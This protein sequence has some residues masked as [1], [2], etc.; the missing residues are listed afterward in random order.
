MTM[1]LVGGFALGVG[2]PLLLCVR[3]TLVEIGLPFVRKSD[4]PGYVESRVLLGRIPACSASTIFPP[5]GILIVAEHR[6]MIPIS[7]ARGCSSS[8][9][10]GAE[11]PH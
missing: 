3:E 9:S 6:R 5:P 11:A 10:G 7:S 8:R 1:V 4:L 2:A